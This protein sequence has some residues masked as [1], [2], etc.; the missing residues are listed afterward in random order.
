M[1]LAESVRRNW[2][3]A[4]GMDE[5]Q[6]DES[7]HHTP[8]GSVDEGNEQ[9]FAMQEILRGQLSAEQC[10]RLAERSRPTAATLAEFNDF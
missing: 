3:R 9:L 10:E 1:T 6:I 5:A 8:M 4:M 2:M 7:V